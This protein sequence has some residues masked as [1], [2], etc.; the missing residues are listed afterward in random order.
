MPTSDPAIRE[1]K[2]WLGY[3]Q[4]KCLVASPAAFVDAQLVLDGNTPLIQKLFS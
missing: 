1:H 2:A 4:Q 3:V